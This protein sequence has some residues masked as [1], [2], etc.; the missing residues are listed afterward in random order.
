MISNSSHERSTAIIVVETSYIVTT[1]FLI[2]VGNIIN[3]IVL[4]KSQL[5]HHST[6]LLLKNLSVVDCCIGLSFTVLAIYPSAADLTEWPYGNFLCTTTSFIGGTCCGVS[7]ITLALISIDRYFIIMRPM[8]FQHHLSV[9]KTYMLIAVAWFI[10][11]SLHGIAIL[12]VWNDHNGTFNSNFSFYNADAFLCSVK[13]SSFGFL[14]GALVICIFL[15]TNVITIAV[16]FP[17]IRASLRHSK[18]IRLSRINGTTQRREK[19]CSLLSDKSNKA[20]LTL[21][22]ITVV[23]NLCWAPTAITVLLEAVS[24]IDFVHPNVEFICAWLAMANSFLNSFVYLAMNS[25]Y[26]K[27]V[28]KLF[29]RRQADE[30]FLQ[31]TISTRCLSSIMNTEV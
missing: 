30:Y 21:L 4:H 23:F 8:D 11:S 28:K 15:P 25:K 2:L 9:R 10:P 31:K 27:A 20:V 7:I 17:I 18:S 6:T 1:A 19:T 12:P 3:I 29:T 14:T 13:Y 16:Y 22:I 24:I 5:W 26:R